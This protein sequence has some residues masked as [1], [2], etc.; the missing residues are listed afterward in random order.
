MLIHRASQEE[1]GGVVMPPKRKPEFFDKTPAI[2]LAQANEIM[3]NGPSAQVDP[4]CPVSPSEN[5]GADDD[6]PPPSKLVTPVPGTQTIIFAGDA[7]DLSQYHL[8]PFATPE[9][10]RAN[11]QAIF[12]AQKRGEIT[13]D[14]ANAL[15]D[16]NIEARILM[17]DQLLR[18]ASQRTV[19]CLA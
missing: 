5:I 3:V 6:P 4:E 11:R 18:P 17:E 16:H 19:L 1:S 12:D 2:T 7:Q 14:E 9:E 8:A 13:G 15:F 10:K